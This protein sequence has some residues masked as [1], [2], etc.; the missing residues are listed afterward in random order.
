MQKPENKIYRR[1]IRW[2]PLGALVI[3]MA[4]VYLNGW[5]QYFSLTTLQNHKDTLLSY[6]LAHP[7]LSVVAFIMVYTVFVALSLPAATLLTLL[8]GFLF[9]GLMGTLYV[10]SAATLGAVIV[11]LIAK[12]ALGHTL[13]ARAGKIYLKIETNMKENAAGYLLFMRL[14]PLFPFFL[15][16]IVPALFNV[17]LVTYIWTTFIGIIPGS[18]VYVNLGKQFADIDHLQDLASPQVVLAFALL[19]V[20]ALIPTIYKQ[21]KNAQKRNGA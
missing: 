18:F 7:V 5:H 19:G 21:L 8:G 3:L 9:G 17:R 1:I 11:F 15:V 20:F 14:V 13:R 16:N 10:V 4:V 6:Q 12:S 2:A